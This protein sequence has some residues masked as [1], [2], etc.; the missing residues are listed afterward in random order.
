MLVNPTLRR[1][2][3]G[4]F[5]IVIFAVL[6][7]LPATAQRRK[8]TFTETTDVVVV[9]VPITV[10]RDGEPVD[11][12]TAESFEILDGGKKQEI[13]GFEMID[14]QNPKTVE[15]PQSV[16]IAARRHFLM[17]FDLSFSRPETLVRARWAARDLI[18]QLHPTDLAGVAIYTTNKGADFLLGFTSDRRQLELAV[19]SL[20]SPR[21]IKREA[22]PLGLLVGNVQPN[23]PSDFFG[24]GLEG[25]RGGGGGGQ[26][27][28]I[29]EALQDNLEADLRRISAT[30]RMELRDKITAMTRN[31]G[32]M[33]KVLGALDGRKHVV[34]FSEGFQEEVLIGAQ[35]T[36]EQINTVASGEIW[37]TSGTDTYGDTGLQN[38]YE[39]MI[40]EFRRAGCTVQAIDI[41]GLRDPGLSNGSQTSLLA[42]ADG[43]GGELY[44]N[45][46]DLGVAMDKMLH[47]TSVTYLLA[48]QPKSLKKDGKYH[49]LK[50][51][52]RDGARGVRLS[53]RAGY[54]A[55]MSGEPVDAR[56]A[57]MT[58]AETLL[59]E[60]VGGAFDVS[61]LTAP[62]PADGKSYLPVL[63]EVD[64]TGLVQSATDVLNLEIYGYALDESG[65]VRDFFTQ[66]LTLDLAKVGDA[67][68]QSGFKYWGHFDLPPGAYTA[69]VLVKETQG[70]RQ[71]L[72]RQDIV[73][74][75]FENQE[76][77][78][79]PPLFPEQP[80]KWVMAREGAERQRDVAYP[81]MIGGQPIIPAVRP[82]VP[83]KGTTAFY[84]QGLH[85]AG[86]VRWSGEVVDAAGSPATA[87]AVTVAGDGTAQ[88]ET[89]GLD[90]GAYTLAVIATD[91]AGEHKTAIRFVV[92]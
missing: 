13:L 33:A 83:R 26:A 72:S 39:G 23:V 63:I 32:D 60:N 85:L 25:G 57:R 21:L 2:V 58:T 44:R 68:K 17:F 81:F 88:L 47:R 56:A 91:A 9:E 71:A 28:S 54:Y 82:E 77:A 79:L 8:K 10:V 80:G 61:V 76:T 29:A 52:L 87:A 65:A 22:D 6:T 19:G 49:K 48:F 73:V 3:L 75:V 40:E 31:L 69:R 55:P 89:R 7:A 92:R 46:N 66:N 53:H 67:L 41:A 18:A 35:R 84:L 20:G 24:G 51:K 45:L 37:N 14:L 43:T 30:E 4:V 11:G 78:L 50:V 12:L 38:D 86:D 70:G 34:Y 15:A 42:F 1:R 5:L 16:P 74:P 27:D 64:G 90:A 59:S 36:E 62:F